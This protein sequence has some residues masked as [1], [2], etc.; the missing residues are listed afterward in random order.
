MEK[1]GQAPVTLVNSGKEGREGGDIL[2]DVLLHKTLTVNATPVMPANTS[3][4]EHTWNPDAC[5]YQNTTDYQGN[6][7]AFCC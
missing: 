4:T 2:E 6:A 7:G 1:G 5:T 3:Q